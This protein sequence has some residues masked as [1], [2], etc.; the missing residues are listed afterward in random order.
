MRYDD[1]I[2]NNIKSMVPYVSARET[3]EGDAD[4]LLDANEMPFAHSFN[5]YP[6]PKQKDLKAAVAS[7]KNCKASQIFFGNGS[8]DIIDI[9]IR[10]FC[11]PK[12]DSV[13][14]FTPGFGMYKVA[15]QLNDVAYHSMSLDQ[16]F[17]FDERA[18]VEGVK[19]QDKLVFLCSPNNPTANYIDIS[20]LEFVISKF[21]GITVVDEAYI[22]FTDMPSCMTLLEKYDRLV[23]LQTFSKAFGAA[24]IRLG[25]GFMHPELVELLNRVKMPYNISVSTQE[26]AFR[27]L[28]HPDR[29]KS[30]LQF[31]K[32]Q[33]L[34][35]IDRLN[36]LDL[37]LQ[38]HPSDTNFFLAKFEKPKAVYKYLTNQGIIVRDRSSLALC[39]GC[40]RVTVGTEEENERLINVLKQYS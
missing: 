27:I 34:H 33:K 6:D 25:M 2:R 16:D 36:E 14:Y 3:F 22:D 17:S 30:N 31:I 35:L 39:E 19:E 28:E 1:L 11:E 5:R 40:L 13:Y 29:I 37:V 20:K 9:L 10:T 24:G 8:D 23:V 12:K 26:E 15:A 18:F 21:N 7:Y 32:D 4:V 38:I